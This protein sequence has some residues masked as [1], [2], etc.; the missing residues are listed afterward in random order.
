MPK[1]RIEERAHDRQAALHD[2]RVAERKNRIPSIVSK[3]FSMTVCSDFSNPPAVLGIS[4]ALSL[5]ILKSL[6]SLIKILLSVLKKY[7]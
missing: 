1:D 3:F 4:I 6:I 2:G 5:L 7:R